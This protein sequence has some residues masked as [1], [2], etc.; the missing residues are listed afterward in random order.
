MRIEFVIG[1]RIQLFL[2][3]SI[4][5]QTCIHFKA[6]AKEHRG[7]RRKET[8][9][10]ENDAVNTLPTKARAAVRAPAQEE[11]KETSPAGESL[12]IPAV[13]LARSLYR[14]ARDLSISQRASRCA[15]WLCML[16]PWTAPRPCLTSCDAL[17]ST[18][19]GQW[20]VQTRRT[21]ALRSTSAG[22]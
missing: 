5:L 13:R 14:R 15:L 2:L 3:V 19:C 18:S 12:V 10:T 20:R 8:P 21:P 9:T 16:A 17:R 4:S 7:K 22:K 1:N 11:K 6:E